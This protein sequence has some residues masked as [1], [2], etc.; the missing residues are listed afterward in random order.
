[1]GSTSAVGP[2][3][4]APVLVDAVFVDAG[5]FDAVSLEA[6]PFEA[7]SF[8]P[9]PQLLLASDPGAWA[10]WIDVLTLSG[11]HNTRVVL[12]AAVLLGVAAGVVGSFAMLKRRSLV[13]D[14]IAH[15]SLAG[16][17]AAFALQH[18]SVT[19]FSDSGDAAPPE[20]S[21]PLLL[22]GAALAGA[23]AV[24]AI[25]WL[26]ARTRLTAD[27]A[28]A[29]VSSSLF[30]AGIVGL[31]MT[32]RME[33]ADQAGLG[34][35][36]LGSTASM[37]EHDAWL[38][39]GLAVAVIGVTALLRKPLVA[40]AFNKRFALTSGLPVRALD[41]V[42]GA[43][44]A[45]ITLAGLQAVGMLLVVALLAIPAAAA[46]LWTKKVAPLIVLAGGLGGLAALLGASAS[47]VLPDV[48]A[49]SLIVLSAAALF[50]AS[51][52]AAPER[53]LVAGLVAGAR[54]RRSARELAERPAAPHE[55]GDA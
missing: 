14:A 31:S 48:P 41:A 55:G 26:V 17:C 11:G 8:E 34:Q 52:I 6:V 12:I 42:L 29:A 16:V 45:A 25:E 54:L 21:L 5:S 35:L 24:A 9:G 51:L 18:L 27:A 15:A 46:R 40:V 39:A 36:I 50:T 38:M 32:R 1:M 43:M 22:L 7:A 53:G 19:F 30:G 2:V 49:G 23:L 10:R 44:V 3:A 28:T 47:A 4:S 37:T 33:G 13:A 20:R